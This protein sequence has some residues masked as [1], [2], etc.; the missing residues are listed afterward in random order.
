MRCL[1]LQLKCPLCGRLCS[2]AKF[3]PSSFE[4]D[5]YEVQVKGLGRGKG[6]EVVSERS[7]L[8]RSHG[9]I[10]VKIKDRILTLVKVLQDAEVLE[11]GEIRS[12]L[13]LDAE[14][15]KVKELE[16]PLNDL[17]IEKNNFDF[18]LD[19]KNN[20]ITSLNEEKSALEKKLVNRDD[21]LMKENIELKKHITELNETDES[22]N[23]ECDS[24]EIVSALSGFLDDIE[25]LIYECEDVEIERQYS[26]LRKL[27]SESE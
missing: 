6:V 26:K 2:I 14:S 27:V 12:K 5:I 11:E 13:E 16:R 21:E 19:E 25:E 22:M 1:N 20:V 24:C 3:D 8:D 15:P 10:V 17:L 9:E 18:R 23:T 4:D 7:I